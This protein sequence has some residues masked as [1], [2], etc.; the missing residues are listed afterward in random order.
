[1][2]VC[3]C[4]TVEHGTKF[5]KKITLFCLAL[6]ACAQMAFGTFYVGTFQGLDYSGSGITNPAGLTIDQRA[7]KAAT[8]AVGLLTPNR[9]DTNNDATSVG[10]VNTQATA[11][12]GAVVSN[13]VYAVSTTVQGPLDLTNFIGLQSKL[14]PRQPFNGGG[15]NTF[16]QWGDAINA[17]DVTNDLI[18]I[19]NL[20]LV[21]LAH[22]K[23]RYTI[24]A[25][26]T[27]PVSTVG[28]G[29]NSSGML[30]CDSNKFPQGMPGIAALIKS[31]GC[32]PSLYLAGVTNDGGFWQ[33]GANIQTNVYQLTQWGF[34]IKYDDQGTDL[35]FAAQM[36]RIT[37]AYLTWA[38]SPANTN[39]GLGAFETG[40]SDFAHFI[41]QNIS[42]AS[43]LAG[44][45]TIRLP[46]LNGDVIT[47]WSQF[48]PYVSMCSQACWM[49]NSGLEGL[50]ETFIFSNGNY[51]NLFYAG[52]PFQDFMYMNFGVW[53]VCGGTPDFSAMTGVGPNTQLV[54]NSDYWN[55]VTSPGNFGQLIQ[56]NSLYLTYADFMANGQTAIQIIPVNT[57]QTTLTTNTFVSLGIPPGYAVQVRDLWYR[58]N[59]YT[60]TDFTFLLPTNGGATLLITPY[61]N[62]V[63]ISAIIPAAGT[64][65]ITGGLIQS[66]APVSLGNGSFQITTNFLSNTNDLL[67]T[68]FPSGY[69][70]A[71][72][73]TNN[74]NPLVYKGGSKHLHDESRRDEHAS[75]HSGFKAWTTNFPPTTTN[76]IDYAGGTNLPTANSF[77]VSATS[78][79]PTISSNSAAPIYIWNP[80]PIG[81]SFSNSYNVILDGEGDFNMV[82]RLLVQ[83][84]V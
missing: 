50:E 60:T 79:Y 57:N 36:N 82:S 75:C 74:V 26:W 64:L 47:N 29:T 25:G 9:Y 67:F 46:G 51:T 52:A 15:D 65:S 59:F 42:L 66:N 54:T 32:T 34:G 27:L 24:D 58:T 70:L 1:M 83:R 71:S 62:Q 30:Y 69:V 33:A 8:N 80:F 49:K 38:T 81:S 53:A 45:M 28:G 5:M 56:S 43:R 68:G 55:I 18:S 19:S 22:G 16:G 17:A 35:N 78:Y 14:Q 3:G 13:P 61:Q 11:A 48:L 77:Y 40:A 76:W 12:A 72:V 2:A 20:Q 10:L 39:S 63:G 23:W 21:A 4:I 7:T 6:L 73:Y 84:R 44:G 31:Y 41:T 37:L